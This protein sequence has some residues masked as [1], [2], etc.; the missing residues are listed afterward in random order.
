M[1]NHI[2]KILALLLLIG[3]AQTLTACVVY[4]DGGHYHHWHDDYHHHW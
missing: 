3:V 2:S 1:R 4:D